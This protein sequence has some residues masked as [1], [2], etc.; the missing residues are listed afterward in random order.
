MFPP[1][2]RREDPM[3]YSSSA[4]RNL[5]AHVQHWQMSQRQSSAGPLLGRMIKMEEGTQLASEMLM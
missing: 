3:E 5:G 4:S 2:F 1:A